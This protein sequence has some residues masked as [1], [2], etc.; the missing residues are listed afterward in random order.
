VARHAAALALALALPAAA[1][2][3][4]APSTP[5]AAA[6]A[7]AAPVG[8]PGS[9]SRQAGP[10]EVTGTVVAVD[11]ATHRFTLRG[12]A[13]TVEVAMDRNTLVY[14]P[15][16]PATVLDVAPGMAARAAIDPR[17]TAYWVQVRGP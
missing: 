8:A 1:A 14:L 6:P 5:E 4:A 11:R 7:D 17:G 12:P 10:S 9:P 2:A 3:Q 15:G 13:G 16:G